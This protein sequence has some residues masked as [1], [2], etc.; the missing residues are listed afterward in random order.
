MQ[1]SLSVFKKVSGM[2]SKGKIWLMLF[3]SFLVVA[4]S[5]QGGLS[6]ER[7]AKLRS[8]SDSLT[9]FE[10]QY[11]KIGAQALPAILAEASKYLGR[12]YKELEDIVKQNINQAHTLV[13]GSSLNLEEGAFV[14]LAQQSTGVNPILF[15]T[16]KF[17]NITGE[18]IVLL[19]EPINPDGISQG[20][21]YKE[22]DPG[23]GFAFKHN[24][25]SKAITGNVAIAVPRAGATTIV[26]GTADGFEFATASL[27]SAFNPER[28]CELVR[29]KVLRNQCI[30]NCS[31]GACKATSTESFWVFGTEPASC[32]CR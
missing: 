25:P 20:L 8:D 3:V 30:G 6:K 15:G 22:L 17:E 1:V 31:S 21:I 24:D 4:C 13:L 18:R 7:I 9:L 2:S 28:S 14:L 29:A 11:G 16:V 26:Y 12:P 27:E 23:A 10:K 19:L 32:G 5:E